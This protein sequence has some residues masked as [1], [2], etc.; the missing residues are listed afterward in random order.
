M[1][2]KLYRP[3]SAQPFKISRS[4]IELFCECPCCFYLD[5]KLGIPR[6]S[7]LPFNLN[8]AVDHLLKKEFDQYRAKGIA[9]PLMQKNQVDAVPF[10][11][12][13]LEDWR[14]NQKGIAYLHEPTQ[15]LVYG[16]VDE[17]WEAP[18]GELILVD[19][20]ATSKAGEVNLDADWQISY[21]RQM[22]VYQWLFRKNG[23]QVSSTGYFLYCNGKKEPPEFNQRLEF[24]LSVIPYLGD[25][26]WIEPK[27]L[28]IQAVLN[29]VRHPDPSHS[30]KLCRY[31]DA[32]ARV[33]GESA[34]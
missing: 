32:A 28:E 22:E 1:K 30:C 23:F 6:P 14:K 8:S 5:R 2:K 3:C 21:K 13:G 11:H 29:G 19:F 26:S 18:S 12:E 24:D 4:K 25:D 27:L 10:R 9:H 31:R 34:G 17:V 7:T 15:F 16:A 33:L 20:K